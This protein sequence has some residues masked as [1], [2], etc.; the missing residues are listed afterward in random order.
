MACLGAALP[1]AWILASGHTLV[2]RD[3]A[4][5]NAA[6]RPMI[7]DSL[8][9]LRV[10]GWN[11]W[12][13][14]G[15]PLFAQL[16]NGVL[17]PVSIALAM[18]TRSTDALIVALYV[19]G[20]LGAWFAARALRVGSAAAAGAALAFA[21]SGYALSMAD[22]TSYLMPTATGPW[23]VAGLLMASRCRGGWAAAA[24]AIAALALS[25]DPGSLF[26]FTLVG[27]ALA[28]LEGRWRGLLSAGL[29]AA[30]GFGLAA[31]QY[32][33]SWIYMADTAR[34]A[35]LLNPADLHRWALAPWRM[36]ELVAPGFFVGVPRSYDAPVFAALDGATPD[37]FPFTPSVFV[38]APVLLLAALGARRSRA[39]RWLLGLALLFLWISLGHRAGGQ[40]LLSWIPIWGALRYWEKMVGPLT[41]C[42]ALA[43]GAGVDALGEG[44][45]RVL[46]RAAAAG[47]ALAA[48][49]A[50]AMSVPGEG[51][52]FADEVAVGELARQHLQIGLVHAT[53]ALAALAVA[54]AAGN[55]RPRFAAAAAVAVIFLQS[56]AASPF[57][58][59]LGSRAA[60]EVRPPALAAPPP[61]PRVVG[62]LGCDFPQG[63]GKLDAIDL[64]N[65]CERRT[66]RPST[67]A[68]AGV[69]SI[70]TYSSLTPHRWDMIIGSGPL[71]W[72]L[73]RR[74]ATSHVLAHPPT[75]EREAGALQAAT[76]GATGFQVLDAGQL[77]VWELPHRPWASFAPAVRIARGR[78]EAGALLA[79]ELEADRP[80]VV[81]E[82]GGSPPA[83]SVGRVLS[84]R[85]AAEEVVI[86][87]ESAADALL[88]VNDA[89]SAGWKA[90]VDGAEVELMPADVLVRAVRWPAGRHR[91]VMRY[92]VPGLL[93]GEILSALAAVVGAAVFAWQR[94]RGPV[95]TP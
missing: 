68:E 76:A 61:G 27:A 88:V 75:S 46:V 65:A 3:T 87:A 9:Q 17:H 1:A 16:L 64:L 14:A 92:E 29:G 62:P 80:T 78:D 86:E 8:R 53:I 57:A 93:T 6:L 56:A 52:V 37:R 66:G 94:R 10:P 49:G 15:Q 24:L 12:E 28:W 5:L 41:L 38:G 82:T 2:W 70:A 22:N 47:A 19:F 51:G 18:L 7:V 81:V 69:D 45:S 36:L 32:V 35:G 72:P 58:L 23:A 84:V 95:R 63:N 34:G 25:G 73:A 26:A 59:H 4:Q 55:R 33:P 48:L 21:L 44:R 50:G 79:E 20:A 89:W 31:V 71:F 74:F 91:L 40:Q 83:I 30:L 11:P 85:R 90:F 77:L 67:N 43:A 39:A 42:L 54:A 60:L 13:G